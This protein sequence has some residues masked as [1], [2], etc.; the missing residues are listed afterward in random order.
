MFIELTGQVQTSILQ[1]PG[2]F[3]AQ[4]S[5]KSTEKAKYQN[6]W[7]PLYNISVL[8]INISHTIHFFPTLHHITEG[9]F[10][11]E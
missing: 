8:F 9:L 1:W 10:N 7:P 4:C 3:L 11:I 6:T 5:S 2:E